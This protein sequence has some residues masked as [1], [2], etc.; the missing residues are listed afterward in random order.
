M[1]S[2]SEMKLSIGPSNNP[3]ILESIGANIGG[4]DSARDNLDDQIFSTLD[5]LE[6][7]YA[8][9]VIAE[10]GDTVL[11]RRQRLSLVRIAAERVSALRKSLE[12]RLE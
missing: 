1:N 5:E 8:A 2:G 9:Q 10:D 11:S 7:L 3:D 12:L 6:A 4:T